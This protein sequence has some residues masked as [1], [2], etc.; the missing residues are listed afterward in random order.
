[1][2]ENVS[3]YDKH[4]LLHV[5]EATLMPTSTQVAQ[6]QDDTNVDF[7]SAFQAASNQA[8]PSNATEEPATILL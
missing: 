5:S 8:G 7:L 6:D 1:M 3:K 4:A 2:S